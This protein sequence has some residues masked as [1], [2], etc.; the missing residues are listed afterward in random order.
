MNKRKI[1]YVIHSPENKF[2]IFSPQIPIKMM[3]I[4]RATIAYLK[5]IC[6]TTN[7]LPFLILKTT[8]KNKIIKKT[9]IYKDIK[10]PLLYVLHVKNGPSL[11]KAK[12]AKQNPN[13][14]SSKVLL[15]S[16]ARTTAKPP[17]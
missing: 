4:T 2:S 11:K 17:S 3:D 15:F 14:L 16:L 9:A 12:K 5:S 6:E 13:I 8:N 7:L 10:I 1:P